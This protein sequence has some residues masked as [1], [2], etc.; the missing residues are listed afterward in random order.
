MVRVHEYP[1]GRLAIYHGP[2]RLADYDA[3]GN[4]GD[5]TRLAA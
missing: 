3:D 2:H 5:A 4:P 1:D